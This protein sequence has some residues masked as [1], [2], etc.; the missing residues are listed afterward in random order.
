VTF[1]QSINRRVQAIQSAVASLG[2]I[3]ALATAAAAETGA[4]VAVKARV[5]LQTHCARCHQA[6]RLENPPAKGDLGNILD[7]T[8][9]SERE[10]LVEP[11]SPDASRLYQLMLAQHRPQSVFYGPVPGPTPAEIG[12]VRDWLSALPARPSECGKPPVTPADV[13]SSIAAWRKAFDGDGSKPLRFISL[14]NLHNLCRSDAT[15]AAYRDAVGILMGR[16]TL[17]PSVNLDTV[18]EASVILA[19]RPADFGLTP[20]GWDLRAGPG[21][22]LPGVVSAESVAA[23]ALAAT[24]RAATSTGTAGIVSA[25]AAPPEALIDGLDPVDALA[26]E[27]RRS[28]TLTRAAVERHVEAAELRRQLEDLSGEDRS[29]GRRL[30]QTGLPREEWEK[31]KARLAGRSDQ[32][33]AG[34]LPVSP[35]AG[36]RLALWTNATDY[37]S[38]ELFTVYARTSAD[39]NLTVVAIESTGLATV[40][41]PND[42]VTDNRVA[43][44]MLVQIPARDAPFQIRLDKTG[45]HSVVGICNAIARRPQGIGHDFERQ[46]FTVLGDWRAFLLETVEREAAYQ[47]AQEDLRRFRTGAGGAAVLEEQL[48]LGAEDEARAGLSVDVRP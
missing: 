31:L 3:I 14:A 43:G 28:V 38:G 17:R 32:Q 20:E 27:Y 39:C 11:A 24:S 12:A 7:L 16:L 46:R 41:F 26:L 2:V 5:V 6:G 10:D 1:D 40:L 13:E 8:R 34:M 47:K 23:R 36:L 33:A 45:R 15:I 21:N 42:A 29:L 48:P 30:M 19:F 35:S 9:L 22:D 44:G 18:G 4:D 25:V 37:R